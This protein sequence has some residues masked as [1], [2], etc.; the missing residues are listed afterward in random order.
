MIPHPREYLSSLR[1]ET[2]PAPPTGPAC[3]VCGQHALEED[4]P[5]EFARGLTDL[6]VCHAC[7]AR[8][9]VSPDAEHTG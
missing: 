8:C 1:T 2:S 4:S 6:L 5:H 3:R 7:G 9:R